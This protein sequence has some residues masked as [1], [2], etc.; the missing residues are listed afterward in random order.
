MNVRSIVA[1]MFAASAFSAGPVAS[2]GNLYLKSTE[3]LAKVR[4]GQTT[5]KE[6]E[7]LIG[8]AMRITRNSRREW[9]QWEYRVFA[10]GQRSTLWI[11]LSDDG[12]VREVVELQERRP[13]T[14]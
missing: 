11:S 1:A 14:T 7:A 2:Q 6:V 9:N 12:V 10:Y 4:V 3:S 13:G 8:P 5:G